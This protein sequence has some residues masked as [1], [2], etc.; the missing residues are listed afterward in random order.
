MAT[1]FPPTFFTPTEACPARGPYLVKV[2]YREKVGYRG[3]QLR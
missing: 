3:L 1:L 2:A